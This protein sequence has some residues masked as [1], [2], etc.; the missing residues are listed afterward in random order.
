MKKVSLSGSSRES[1]GKK[2]AKKLRWQG[3]VPC[4]L[5]GGEKQH[6][7]QCKE[8]DLKK[9]IF[10]PDVY[11]VD[12]TVDGKNTSAVLKDVQTHPVTG[13]LVHI[14]FFELVDGKP[15][16]LE[17]PVRI[18]GSAP[19]VRAGGR[20]NINFRKIPVRGMAADLPEAIEI[21]VSSL[22]IG[23]GIRINDLNIPGL[24]IMVPPTSQLMSIKRSR[25]STEPLPGAEADAG[26]ADSAEGESAGS[27]EPAKEEA[28]E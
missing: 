28:G 13:K 15:V 5:Y 25:V 19:G 12:L 7:F 8:L 1:V 10:S 6:H 2:D 23:D 26:A 22:G 18:T 9:I 17:L 21:D 4:V 3:L 14:D 11:L 24:T 27:E 16:S 20:M